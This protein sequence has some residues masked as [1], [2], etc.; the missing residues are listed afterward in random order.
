VDN[1]EDNLPKPLK[2]TALPQLMKLHTLIALPPLMY[3]LVESVEPTCI[4]LNTLTQEPA[5]PKA[6]KLTQEPSE[7]KFIIDIPPSTVPFAPLN[8]LTDE[9]IL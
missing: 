3:D 4:K 6:L 9:P 7:A 1:D 8:R 2:L 5:L